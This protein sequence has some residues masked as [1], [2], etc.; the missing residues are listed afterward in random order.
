M[1]GFFALLFFGVLLGDGKQAPVEVF[2][3]T[4]AIALYAAMRFER[5]NIRSSPLVIQ[6]AWIA[7]FGIAF[8]SG[9]VSISPGFSFSWG[10]RLLTGYLIYILFSSMPGER[11]AEVFVDVALL[12]TL[13]VSAASLAAQHFLKWE[14]ALPT[15]NLLT[16][17]YGHN[18]L[19]NLLV[20]AVPLLWWRTRRLSGVA[21][22]II[23]GGYGILLWETGARGAWIAVAA[24]AIVTCARQVGRQNRLALRPAAASLLIVGYCLGWLFWTKQVAL[25]TPIVR[26][27][28]FAS[29]EMYW[30]QALEGM[31]RRPLLGNGPGTFSLISQQTQRLRE[32]TSWFAH[33]VVFET[34]AEMGLAGL[35]AVG[36]LVVVIA[37]YARRDGFHRA[38]SADTA[39]CISVLLLLFYGLY[40]FVLSHF[41]VWLLVW[42]GVGICAR[43]APS[44]RPPAKYHWLVPAALG[45]FYCSW[46]ISSA[47][48]YEGNK[49]AAFYFAPYDAVRAIAV[50]D[51]TNEAAVSQSTLGAIRYFHR[52]NPGILHALSQR[53]LMPGGSPGAALALEKEAFVA[54]PQESKYASAYLSQSVGLSEA[55]AGTNAIDVLAM[56]SVHRVDADGLRPHAEAIGRAVKAVYAA[57]PP[58]L[59]QGYASL[60]YDLGLALL[61]Q[62]PG[63]TEL[64]WKYARDSYPDLAAIHIELARFYEYVYKNRSMAVGILTKCGTYVSARL[65][66]QKSLYGPLLPPGEFGNELE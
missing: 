34:G 13:A 15:M 17:I 16:E 30:R 37:R 36:W 61:Y 26:E 66:C 24:L 53:A 44:E 20:F 62:S 42:A 23:V 14:D 10:I 9:V 65:Q 48:A 47:A 54:N 49:T 2:G 55:N 25:A 46:L 29:R 18:H 56:G 60:A 7:L 1:G 19:A 58:P 63:V 57:A 31:S 8:V 59:S 32:S 4:S 51:P 40:E 39:L 21:R 12:F 38:D 5:W 28:S 41:I 22:G 11:T 52:K 50:A 35:L 6:F 64:L 45:A 27:G 3:V 33:S 43:G